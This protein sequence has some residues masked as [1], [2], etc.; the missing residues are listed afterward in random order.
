MN[1]PLYIAR[2]I[3]K[4]STGGYSGRIIKLAIASI[5]LSI[6]VMILTTAVL[7]GFKK[8]ISDKVYGFWGHIHI[9]DTKLSRNF[10]L[11][12]I[13]NDEGIKDSI[14]SI[15]YLE[16][17][18]FLEPDK[19]METKGGV[20]SISPFI[21]IPGILVNKDDE[22]EA[23]ILKGV[24]QEYVWDKF[25]SYLR[26]GVLPAIAKDTVS[27][28]MMISEQ[29]ARRMRV[30]L[31]DKLIVHFVVDKNP[32]KRAFKVSGIYRTG[33]EEYDQ[34]FAFIDMKVIQDVLKW[35]RNQVGG[36]EVFVEHIEDSEPIADYVHEEILPSNMYTET[37]LEKFRN[38]FDWIE[39]QDING[40]TLFGLMC[41]V[42]LI[43]MCT[44]LLI[45][46]LERSKMV[47]ILKSLGQSNWDV[48]KIFIYNALWILFIALLIGN[49][50]GIGLGWIQKLT[51]VI[52]LDEQSYYLSE[53]P[54]NFE[55]SAIIM[56]NLGAIVMTALVMLIPT[57]LISTITPIKMLRFD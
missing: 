41:I 19:I 17:S 36:F 18:S 44:A 33:L 2:R 34:K 7:Y 52:K 31:G 54:I 50:L 24:N 1:V 32:I 14:R 15:G 21:N 4:S 30:N 3:S 23:I 8:G 37:I 10:E 57:F 53:V 11:T 27:R 29:T 26:K 9:S 40:Y 35:D 56:I 13:I 43:N 46:I 47:G 20:E 12:P 25:K 22:L 48:R 16:F 42:A 6:T 39:M 38:M 5:A 49:I 28:E 51:G 55:V 45:L